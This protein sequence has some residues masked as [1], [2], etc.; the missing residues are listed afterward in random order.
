MEGQQQA[1]GKKG[2]GREPPDFQCS[3]QADTEDCC[4]LSMQPWVGVWLC[5]ATNP[6]PWRVDMEQFEVSGPHGGQR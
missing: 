5:E 3:G 1:W 6:S 2:G 4:L